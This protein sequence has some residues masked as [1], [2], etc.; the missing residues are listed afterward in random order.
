MAAAGV[1]YCGPVKTRHKGFCLDT[2]E[3]LIKDWTGGS[4]IFMKSTPI[5][6]DEIPLLAIG[7]KYNSR[8]VL[9][10]ISTEGY[11]SNEPG[12]PYLYCFPDIYSN[13]S[14]C[15]VVCPHLLGSYFNV[16]VES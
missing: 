16:T 13:V 15:P 5:F 2:S 14:I 6:P 8:K 11:G 1:D 7:Y 9:G 4:Y 3:K 10:F 12:D